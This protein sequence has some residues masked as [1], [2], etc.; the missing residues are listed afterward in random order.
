MKVQDFVAGPYKSTYFTALC[1]GSRQPHE[2]R[3]PQSTRLAADTHEGDPPCE[4]RQP[5]GSRHPL[6]AAAIHQGPLSITAASL[7]TAAGKPYLEPISSLPQQVEISLPPCC[8]IGTFIRS[9]CCCIFNQLLRSKITT[10]ALSQTIQSN[11]IS[12]VTC[13]LSVEISFE[14]C[15]YQRPA[16]KVLPPIVKYSLCSIKIRPEQYCLMLLT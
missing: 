16:Y 10:Y 6:P 15:I 14:I 8:E 13:S 5:C 1:F 9:L 12:F 7:I 2:P 3:L 11:A 4:S